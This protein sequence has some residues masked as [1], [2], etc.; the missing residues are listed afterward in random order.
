MKRRT[1]C[2]LLLLGAMLFCV[3]SASAIEVELVTNGNLEGTD[4]SSFLAKEAPA[5][6]A[7]AV[8]LYNSSSF[9]FN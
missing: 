9:G 1:L 6:E 5:V 7:G 3:S 8:P 2:N 4:F